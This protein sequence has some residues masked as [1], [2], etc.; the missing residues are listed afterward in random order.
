MAQPILLA[1][2]D[3]DRELL[4]QVAP[5]DWRPPA[6]A[7]RYDLVVLGAGTAGLIAAAGAA[8]LG[9]KVALVERSLMG[10]DCLN[11]G[12]VPSKAIL[13]A[14]KALGAAR[15]A[16]ELGLRV[17]EA[18]AD[19][20]AVMERMRRLRAGIGQHDG[21]QRYTELGVDVFLGDGRFTGR[22]RLAVE[23][24]GGASVS[25]RFKRAVIA[26]GARPR[27]L[28]VPGLA[29][30][31]YRTNH[32]LYTLTELPHSLVVVGAGPIGVEMAQA[33]ARFGSQVSIVGLDERVLPR[34]DPDAAAIV[35]RSLERDGVRLELGAGLS[36]VRVEGGRKRV[37]AARGEERVELAGAELLMAAGRAANVE[38]LGLELAGVDFDRRG[39]RVDD[40]LRTTNRRIFAA[41]DVAR[42][43]QFTHA[44]DAMARIALRNAFF[45]GRARVSALTMPWCTYTMPEVAHVGLD[46]REA[47]EAGV[48]LE[49]LRMDFSEVDRARLD[50]ETEGFAKLV[51]EKRSGRLRGATVVAPQA[52]EL[53]GAALVAVSKRLKVG[54]LSGVIHPYPTQGAVWGR[55]GDLAMRRKLTPGAARLLRGLIRM[56]R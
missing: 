34:E 31:G 26:T 27:V 3:H 52:G 15:R 46:E 32:T 53:I 5:E 41:G 12:C 17:P 11:H 47:A 48:G 8:G 22:D 2:D 19:F 55:L 44:A 7:D 28:E 42:R 25:L 29:E 6:P 51:F 10:G 35:R 13:R 40:F 30:A 1:D 9:A 50:G 56:R 38:G 4:Q 37:V 45:F 14:A 49:S 54:E 20:A 36:E 18:E 16:E 24:H 21:A 39:V 43:W 23:C 33:F